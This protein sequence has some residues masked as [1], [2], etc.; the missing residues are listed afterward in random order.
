MG[1]HP[2]R[3]AVGDAH[4][5]LSESGYLHM[6]R[7]TWISDPSK[8]SRAGDSLVGI[9]VHTASMLFNLPSCLGF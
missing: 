9:Q 7:C 8:R 1:R 3:T 2:Q 6:H 5:E 4:A